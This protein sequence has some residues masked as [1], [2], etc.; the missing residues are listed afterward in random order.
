MFAYSSIA[1]LA[2]LAALSAPV[3]SLASPVLTS[4]SGSGSGKVNWPAGAVVTAGPKIK[5]GYAGYISKMTPDGKH[6]SAVL[7]VKDAAKSPASAVSAT[8]V[9]TTSVPS[10]PTTSGDVQGTYNPNQGAVAPGGAPIT[11]TYPPQN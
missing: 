5:S 10:T 6:P 4:P 7:W 8:G 11:M 3:V 2:A 9:A 1:G